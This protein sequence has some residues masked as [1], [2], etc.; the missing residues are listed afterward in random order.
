[1]RLGHLDYIVCPECGKGLSFLETNEIVAD[2]LITGLL[3]C[4]GCCARFPVVKSIPRFVSSEN[5]AKS[6]GF[7]W[8]MH[9]RSQYD[10]H[11]RTNISEKRFFT[12]TQ[13]PRQLE[14]EFMLEVGS[15]AGRF[16]EQAIKTKAM[17][18]SF[19]YSSAVEA[20]HASNGHNNNLLIVQAD[21]YNLPFR[22]S[23]FDKI[24]CMGVLQFTPNPEKSFL[25]LPQYLKSGGALTID[26]FNKIRGIKRL[27]ATKYLARLVT[28][29][30]K[31]ER[32][33]A[34][35]KSYI[36]F[37]WPIS[38][39]FNKIPRFG[40]TLNWKLLIS[41]YRGTYDLS[42]KDLKDWAVLDTFNMLSP[43]FEFPQDIETVE[44]WFVSAGLKN[45]DVSCLNG[46]I[47]ARGIKP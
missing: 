38:K 28:R 8:N 40:K 32:L 43:V 3:Q 14:G 21:L 39:C 17:V 26:A 15:G 18:V 42:E 41:D 9:A 25:T 6:F 4:S 30:M 20:N 11:T 34:Y 24:F 29:G 36:D 7:E 33:Y 1:M 44:K 45:A 23:F 16:T 22:K 5:Y 13:W 47:V 46:L 35:C 31:P 12:E 27:F 19:D 10:S 2:D 37:I